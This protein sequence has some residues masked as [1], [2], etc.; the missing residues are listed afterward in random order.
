[1]SAQ[2]DRQIPHNAIP[3]ARLAVS[4]MQFCLFNGSVRVREE[5][6]E[7]AEPEPDKQVQLVPQ[8]VCHGAPPSRHR[9]VMSNHGEDEVVQRQLPGEFVGQIPDRNKTTYSQA[10]VHSVGHVHTS[11]ALNSSDSG[12]ASS[13]ALRSMTTRETLSP[14]GH[15]RLQ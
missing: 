15:T 10:R 5:G 9:T 2:N 13:M 7:Q 12:N 11:N 1:M 6:C 14:S 4:P 3:T 8:D